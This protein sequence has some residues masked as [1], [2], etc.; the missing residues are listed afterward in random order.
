MKKITVTKFEFNPFPVNTYI[1]ADRDSNECIIIDAGCYYE[2]EQNELASFI[3]K[4]GL[5]VKHLLATHL[6]LDHCFGNPF[7]ARR[8]NLPLEAN[9]EDE[10]L[11]KNMQNQ[12]AMFGM[13]LPEPPQPIGHY[14]QEDD[15][16]SIGN[17]QLKA[18]HVPGHS[19]G[20]IVYYCQEEGF[21]IVGDVLFRSSIGRTDLPGGNQHQLIN[22]IHKK[23]LTLLDTTI[24][25]SGHGIEST[26]GYE[27]E[28]NPYL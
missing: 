14:I 5:K 25:Y 20:S 21:A 7:A 6:H 16:F 9:K 23:L 10:F 1:V 17:T 2:E 24:I 18:I 15:T 11:L 22:G 4:N 27:R 26:I 3:E 28:N 13:Q 19:P 12:A 8:F